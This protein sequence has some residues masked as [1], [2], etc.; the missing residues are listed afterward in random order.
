MIARVAHEA[1][2]VLHHDVVAGE[3]LQHLSQSAGMIG[4][5]DGQHIRK[6]NGV[7]VIG[8][9]LDRLFVVRHNAA[10]NAKMRGIRHGE[11]YQVDVI[12]PKELG[13][14]RQTAGSVFDENGNLLYVHG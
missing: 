5:T 10:Q 3:G 9:Q 2:E 6:L 13:K 4:Y 11:G 12:V 1:V 7:A 8:N 14:M